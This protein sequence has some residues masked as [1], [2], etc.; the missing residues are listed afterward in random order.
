MHSRQILGQQGEDLAVAH[1]TAQ[2]YHVLHRNWRPT[3]TGAR[4][5]LDIIARDGSVLAICEVK[6]RRT[7]AL[8]SP[9]EAVAWD[10]RRRLRRLTGLYLQ[11]FP[12]PGPVRGDVIGIDVPTEVTASDTVVQHLRGVW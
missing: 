12:H 6:T 2:G 10:K 5:E 7:W 9:I 4:G 11:A 3:G 1:L 8:G